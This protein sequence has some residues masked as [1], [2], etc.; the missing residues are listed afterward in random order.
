MVIHC[1]AGKDRTGWATALLLSLAGVSRPDVLADYLRTNEFS[2]TSI[3]A[4]VDEVRTTSGP[5]AAAAIEPALGVRASY[6]NA[7]FEVVDSRFGGID[8]YLEDGLGLAPSTL[9]ALR[10][11]LVADG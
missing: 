5:S 6:L 1:T 3:A 9:A 2:A 7:A 8:R 11:K 10:A 4:A